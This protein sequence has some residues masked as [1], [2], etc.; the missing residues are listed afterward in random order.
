MKSHPEFLEQYA[1]ARE[2]QTDIFIDEIIDIADSTEN[3]VQRDRL[4]IDS[5]KWIAS[6][7]KPKKYGAFKTIEY[8]DQTNAPVD[9][10][11]LSYSELMLLVK[12]EST[13]VKPDEIKER[14]QM[15]ED[16]LL[17]AEEHG[18]AYIE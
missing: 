6:K 9:P 15:L 17:T 10:R 7:L 5:R 13:P 16:A 4:R 11:E 18:G 3:D 8:K 14:I 12:K 1:R 2:L